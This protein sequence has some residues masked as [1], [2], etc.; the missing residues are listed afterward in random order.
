MGGVITTSYSASLTY[1]QFQNGGVNNILR[2]RDFVDTGVGAIGLG[3]GTL[4]AFGIISNPVGWAIGAGVLIYGGTTLI[5]DIY[6]EN[7]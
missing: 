4:A 2:H 1:Q 5:Y 3:A 7:K 6:S